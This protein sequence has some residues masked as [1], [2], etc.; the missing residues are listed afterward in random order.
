MT[1]TEVM[2]IVLGNEDLRNYVLGDLALALSRLAN[3]GEAA[4]YAATEGVLP[5]AAATALYDALAA[6]ARAAF[7]HRLANGS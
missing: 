7:A 6:A 5:E 2:H 1:D 4:F 3:N